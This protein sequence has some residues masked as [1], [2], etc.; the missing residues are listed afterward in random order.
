MSRRVLLLL[1]LT[2]CVLVAGCALAARPALAAVPAPEPRAADLDWPAASRPQT[3]DCANV[4]EI[5]QGECAALV[6]LYNSTNGP[7]WYDNT[8][9][10]QTTTPCSWK[11]ISC[12]VGHLSQLNLQSNALDGP[13]PPELGN[14]TALQYLNLAGNQLSGAIPPELGNLTALQG[15]YLGVNR[16][17]GTIPSALGNLN[18]LQ[19]LDL[20]ANYLS[21]A[22]PPELG[23]LHALI[24]LGLGGN[25]LSGAIPSEL[26]NL[27]ALIGLSLGTNQLSGAIPPTLGDLSGLQR[28]FLAHNQLSGVIPPELGNLK[29]VYYLNLGDNQLNGPIPPELGNLAAVQNLY[30]NNNHLSGAIPPELGNLA[31]MGEQLLAG[32]LPP[33]TRPGPGWDIPHDTAVTPVPGHL[34]AWPGRARASG[35]L[36]V[37]VPPPHHGYLDLSSNQLSGAMP[38]ELGKLGNVCCFD[39]SNNQLNGAAVAVGYYWRNFDY[40]RLAGKPESLPLWSPRWDLTQTVAP[41]NL[42][43]TAAGS[44]VTLTW[45]PILYTGDG[46]YYEISYATAP[47]GPF[48]VHG[49]TADKTANNYTVTGLTPDIAYYFRVRTFTPSHDSPD[50][51]LLDNAYYQQSDLWSDYTTVVSAGGLTPTPTATST[52]TATPTPTPTATATPT[53]TPT[54]TA[55]MTTT[56]TPFRWWFP[57]IWR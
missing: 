49:H 32:A 30:L 20:S 56:P 11:G 22:I 48:V 46:G 17:S 29:A 5:P 34:T 23:N 50:G 15:L 38:P 35:P 37:L 12:A 51:L 1:Y 7:G 52:A 21:G 53:A 10:L 6:A 33:A 14:L 28:L 43:A 31:A 39:V 25:Q 47:G 13:I 42:Q 41:T 40:N 8:G 3:F 18:T 44:A 26:G 9:W 2:V 54:P 19:H 36:G 16:F 4:T 27:Y 57:L 24:G 45:T 55:T